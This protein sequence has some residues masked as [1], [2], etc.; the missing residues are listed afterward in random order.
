MQSRRMNK[1]NKYTFELI[2]APGQ[3]KQTAIVKARTREGAQE[4]LAAE[5][6]KKD[7]TAEWRLV[8]FEL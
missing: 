4:K 5:L 7:I 3:F 1:M 2:T 6:G 8:K